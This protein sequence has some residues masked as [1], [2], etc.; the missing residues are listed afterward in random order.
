MVLARSRNDGRQEEEARSKTFSNLAWS[1]DVALPDQ[2]V[3]ALIRGGGQDKLIV[4]GELVGPASLDSEPSGTQVSLNVMDY[5]PGWFI[6][7]K[8]SK[9]G[10]ATSQHLSHIAA[11]KGIQHAS[12]PQ[13]FAPPRPLNSPAI[14]PT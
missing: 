5:R 14:R 3:V 6:N 1:C 11:R 10:K 13:P 2:T 4:A 7:L 8:G 12:R 9:V